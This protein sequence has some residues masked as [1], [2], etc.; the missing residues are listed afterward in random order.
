[1]TGSHLRFLA[2]GIAFGILVGW[3]LFRAYELAPSRANEGSAGVVEGPA[4]PRAPS[5]DRGSAVDE[6]A[7]AMAEVARLR[8]VLDEN[9]DDLDAL[10]GL[11]RLYLMIGRFQDAEPYLTRAAETY[12]ERFDLQRWIGEA[13]LNVGRPELAVAYLERARDLRPDDA[14]TRKDLGFALRESGRPREALREFA[15]A[16]ER[17][18]GDWEALYNAVVIAGLELGRVD[19]ARAFLEDLEAKRPGDPQ[20]RDLRE[21]FEAETGRSGT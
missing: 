11:G 9:P 6:S 14:A 10:V 4:G 15:V 18:P 17:D 2:V 1:M 16:I 20:V 5:M 13:Y 8:A 19:E 3:G 7:P 21:R 12:P